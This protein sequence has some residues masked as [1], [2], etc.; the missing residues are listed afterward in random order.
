MQNVLAL[1]YDQ[2]LDRPGGRSDGL[3]FLSNKK[4]IVVDDK[5]TS[6]ERHN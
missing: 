2:F 4:R 6:I 3:C 1:S 5:P